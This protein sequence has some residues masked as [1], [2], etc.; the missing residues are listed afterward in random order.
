MN[1]PSPTFCSSQMDQNG[2][3]AP[4][5]Q[6]LA[7]VSVCCLLFAYRTQPPSVLNVFGQT[8]KIKC[9]HFRLLPRVQNLLSLWRPTIR[10]SSFLCGEQFSPPPLFA[11]RP[12]L[13]TGG[14][15]GHKRN[16]ER[17]RSPRFLRPPPFLLPRHEVFM[18]LSSLAPSF[19]VSP[20]CGQAPG[21]PD[22][23]FHLHFP[24]ERFVR[25][26]C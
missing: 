22:G 17:T 3:H 4:N 18:L 14:G 5:S 6:W 2:V 11:E 21:W 12:P 8:S 20:P 9:F 24:F 13:P 26:P 7:R 16:H 23:T 10:R 15:A 19:C 1:I 25:P